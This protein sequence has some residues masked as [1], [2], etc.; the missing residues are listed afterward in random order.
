LNSSGKIPLNDFNN[1]FSKA[2]VVM[3]LKAGYIFELFKK[4]N[5]DTTFKINN[6]ADEKYASMVVVNAPGTTLKPPRYFYPGSPRWFTC[7]V[8]ISYRNTMR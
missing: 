7:T 5:I 2:W 3:N 8:N 4:L 6:L 1:Q